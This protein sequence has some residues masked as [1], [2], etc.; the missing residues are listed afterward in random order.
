MML[1]AP[2]TDIVG[3]VE[4][5]G[6][7]KVNCIVSTSPLAMRDSIAVRALCNGSAVVTPTRSAPASRTRRIN[8]AV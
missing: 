1:R 6:L 7:R 5:S 4:R 8:S 2:G 3:V